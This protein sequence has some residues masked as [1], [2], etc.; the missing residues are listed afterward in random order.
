MLDT[1][2]DIGKW[3]IVR[4]LV[5]QYYHLFKKHTRTSYQTNKY[6]VMMRNIYIFLYIYHL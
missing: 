4:L 5:L 3:L 6:I 2:L 1:G